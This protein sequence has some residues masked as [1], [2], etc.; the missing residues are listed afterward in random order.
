MAG[1]DNT[2]NPLYYTNISKGYPSIVEKPIISNDSKHSKCESSLKRKS[3]ESYGLKSI[4]LDTMKHYQQRLKQ[5]FIP[6]KTPLSSSEMPHSCD[7][8]KMRQCMKECM[9]ELLE[10]TDKYPAID[11]I[12]DESSDED[13][14]YQPLYQLQQHN[15]K[16]ITTVDPSTGRLCQMSIKTWQNLQMFNASTTT[17]QSEHK[18]MNY[19]FLKIDKP[20]HA[21][22]NRRSSNTKSGESTRT[23]SN[24]DGNN[25]NDSENVNNDLGNVNSYPELIA[26]AVGSP[27]K[28]SVPSNK[29]TIKLKC[30][31]SKYKR[32][33]TKNNELSSQNSSDDEA[34]DDYVSFSDSI[35]PFRRKE[36]TS[37][38]LHLYEKSDI[39]KKKNIVT[40]SD[41]ASDNIYVQ[42]S[43][44]ED[45]SDME[46]TRV[47][48]SKHHRIS[49]IPNS[50]SN[51][52]KNGTFSR[53]ET[54]Q[55]TQG[56]F[57][58]KELK[59]QR[60]AE[61]RK[62]ECAYGATSLKIKKQF[63]QYQRSMNNVQISDEEDTQDSSSI[64]HLPKNSENYTSRSSPQSSIERDFK[65]AR[66]IS[67]QYTDKKQ[68]SEK[69]STQKKN[70][71]RKKISSDDSSS[72]RDRSYTE[73]SDKSKTPT[74]EIKKQQQ[75]DNVK[76]LEKSKRLESQKQ[77]NIRSSIDSGIGRVTPT[78]E[79]LDNTEPKKRSKSSKHSRHSEHSSSKFNFD[80]E[81][82]E[83]LERTHM[84]IQKKLN[85]MPNN[86]TN[87]NKLLS[88]PFINDSDGCK[89]DDDL[90]CDNYAKD[91]IDPKNNSDVHDDV[92]LE[93]SQEILSTEVTSDKNK[94][95]HDDSTSICEEVNKLLSNYSSSDENGDDINSIANKKFVD[96]SNVTAESIE[97][98]LIENKTNIKSSSDNNVGPE[99]NLA[100]S[101][102]NKS[103]IDKKNF[104]T[105]DFLNNQEP[106]K[107]SQNCSSDKNSNIKS[108]QLE[109]AVDFVRKYLEKRTQENPALNIDQLLSKLFQNDESGCQ[110]KPNTPP[111]IQK[112]PSEPLNKNSE[113]N[114][115][116]AESVKA[117]EFDDKNQNPEKVEVQN[118]V[119]MLNVLV[120]VHQVENSKITTST[121]STSTVTV[122]SS[123]NSHNF[124][125][126][127]PTA[128]LPTTSLITSGSQSG[129]HFA[130]SNKPCSLTTLASQ[131]STPTLSTAT[132]TTQQ[133]PPYRSPSPETLPTPTS[134]LPPHQDPSTS[135]SSTL[136][137]QKPPPCSS[138]FPNEHCLQH[139]D[140]SGTT[141]QIYCCGNDTLT[142]LSSIDP[143]KGKTVKTTSGDLNNPNTAVGTIQS[144]SPS[145]TMESQ[146]NRS[147]VSGCAFPNYP[148]ELVTNSF[149]SPTI[150]YNLQSHSQPER[151]ALQQ[152]NTTE[153]MSAFT[154][155][156]SMDQ[157]QQNSLRNA[158]L[159]ELLTSYGNNQNPNQ[160]QAS[161][162]QPSNNILTQAPVLSSDIH[163]NQFQQRN[164]YPSPV[165]SPKVNNDEQ[166][167][168]LPKSSINQQFNNQADNLTP[169]QS[170]VMT[171]PVELSNTYNQQYY[172]QQL[173]NQQLYNQQLYNQQLYNQQLYD[174][175]RSSMSGQSNIVSN[176]VLSSNAN[177]N[178]KCNYHSKNLT[179][180]QPNIASPPVSAFKTNNNQQYNS[181]MNTSPYQQPYTVSTPVAP[182][183]ITNNQQFHNQAIYNPQI[184][185]QST[186]MYQQQNK[187][188]TLALYPNGNNSQQYN[189]GVSASMSQ[190]SYISS[191][192]RLCH[193]SCNQINTLNSQK[194]NM[195]PI[196]G[197]NSNVN[198]RQQYNN[199]P[200]IPLSQQ[201]NI[202]PTAQLSSNNNQQYQN[203]TN[204]SIPQQSNLVPPMISF[205][206]TNNNQ[207]YNNQP[208]AIISKQ[209][210]ISVATSLSSTINPNQQNY[211]QSEVLAQQLKNVPTSTKVK[212]S[213]KKVL[214]IV[215]D[216]RSS[217]TIRA[218]MQQSSIN[219]P[220]AVQTNVLRP[221]NHNTTYQDQVQTTI[222][223]PPA[224]QTNVLRPANHNTTNQGQIQTTIHPPT[225]VQTNVLRQANHNTANQVVAQQFSINP[226]ILVQSGVM[227][228]VNYSTTNR[229][230]VQA[231]INPPTPVPSDVSRPI[232]FNE[233]IQS[234][235][236]LSSINPQTSIPSG[237]MQ[238]INHS[239]ANR[240]K[241]QAT[242]NVPIS[243]PSD[244]S[245]PIN[246]NEVIQAQAQTS[247]INPQISRQSGGSQTANHGSTTNRS[248]I[249]QPFINPLIASPSDLLKKIDHVQNSQTQARQPSTNPPTAAQSGV[250][251]KVK[252]STAANQVQVQRI[253]TNIPTSLQSGISQQVDY[254]TGNQ[255]RVQLNSTNPSTSVQSSIVQQANGSEVI[256]AQAQ[257]SSIN[258]QTSVQ[259]GVMQQINHSTANQ[260]QVQ[261]TINPPT[262]VPSDV[263]RPINFNEVI[264]AQAQPSSINSQTSVPSGVMQQINH[265]TANR[266][267][268]Q[269]TFNAP[270]SAPSDV[271]RPINFNEV[272]QTQAQTSSINPQTS[273]QSGGSQTANH[274]STTNRF[275]IQQVFIN[276][277][278]SVQPSGLHKPIFIQLVRPQLNCRLLIPHF[279]YGG[280]IY[281][282]KQPVV[283]LFRFN[284]SSLRPIHQLQYNLMNY[285]KIIIIEF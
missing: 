241:V 253:S 101:K 238:K 278:Y 98:N 211:N 243:V 258:P 134:Q 269:A 202:A 172:N 171:T 100:E 234:Q 256:Q 129:S 264:Q 254:S 127:H 70:I 66:H 118:P 54:L 89:T 77:K 150:N 159:L 175:S 120:D 224:V 12:Q 43:N 217:K 227:D 25:N 265:S 92:F 244:V 36:K 14:P 55:R 15:S 17:I 91:C 275:Q 115:N 257:L 189:N 11:E 168:N 210:K 239:T 45:S 181:Q 242:F 95:I 93:N 19:G 7:P 128:A 149:S 8:R 148:G 82:V 173:Y 71:D 49:R 67:S 58:R 69:N 182:T 218:Q 37:M 156:K 79:A 216:K 87:K 38:K 21:V 18:N 1:N 46:T 228:Q 279:W 177:N 140:S 83:S 9:R 259:S 86:E 106:S 176:P 157:N 222:N 158:M 76:E 60:R 235:A 102:D 255:A 230:Q 30:S 6:S 42:T 194:P 229:I 237:V 184:Y 180:P 192:S 233:V 35:S 267:P 280:L 152:S 162:N 231:T 203:Q 161:V 240:I 266:I 65:K 96:N 169:Q 24:N 81:H 29:A 26:D 250:S 132:P 104:D 22:H 72:R 204:T 133:L 212:R 252:F 193:P 80:K 147:T 107:S 196:S 247:S 119:F 200:N 144:S 40:E 273:V 122:T 170:N 285:D 232:N 85:E 114:S 125:T 185:S 94:T 214:G 51:T 187:A 283:N 190:Q 271:S 225:P 223:P 179:V 117:C 166:L 188:Q 109:C 34:D 31:Y 209:H 124:S 44:S 27:V 4:Q 139:D 48:S 105:N 5:I 205:S 99:N 163:Y 90:T 57:R 28:K 61:K 174:Q 126:I 208:E 112:D 59:A 50:S 111:P 47:G 143:Q 160:F 151:S 268:V 136:I 207:R 201:K 284:Y 165:P 281:C 75:F 146:G 215:R 2:L 206:L 199:G 198:N 282:H 74:K 63:S 121:P 13:Q 53:E 64:K 272:I 135:L 249:Q 167:Y 73:S 236:Q 263:S 88:L 155:S 20:K 68:R 178:R 131:I 276:P 248:Q 97:T 260:I 220:T 262:P 78:Q 52:G 195:V 183:N 245:Q 191:A 145:N 56:F 116:V 197:L 110:C 221:A 186:S 41:C 251:Q 33:K 226:Q 141:V 164:I 62:N 130:M 219:L 153:A 3:D 113:K 32:I 103:I 142:K 39:L 84:K 16:S 10:K 23:H 138:L 261:A 108:N 277:P 123:T 154:T 213:Q 246:F 270:T 137:I 274:C